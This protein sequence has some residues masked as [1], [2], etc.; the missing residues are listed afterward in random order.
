MAWEM[1][2]VLLNS[3]ARIISLSDLD[4]PPPQVLT[5]EMYPEDPADF[6]K[7]YREEHLDMMAKVP[8]FI[9]ALR[10]KLGPRAPLTKG[11]D[12]PTYLAIY[13]VDDAMAFIGHEGS[14]AA[15]ATE[16]SK[17]HMAGSKAFVVRGWK[18]MYD[19]GF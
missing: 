5:V 7:W 19:E 10:Y 12:P 17:T 6:D 11:E 18:R 2:C 8:G 14:A 3:A 1:V 4:K 13:E 9:R 16:W 15:G